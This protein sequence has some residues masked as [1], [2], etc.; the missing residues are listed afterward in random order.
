MYRV[1][2]HPSELEA[3][4]PPMKG[5]LNGP[6][7]TRIAYSEMAAPRCELFQMSDSTAGTTASGLAP[8]IP[9][10]KRQIISVW[11][12][13]ATADAMVNTA[14]PSMPS[15]NGHRLPNSSEA[16]AQ[17]TGPAAKPNTKSD[18]PSI[19]TSD[20][21]LKD[22]AAAAEPGA[23]TPLAKDGINVPKH[24]IVDM[25]ILREKA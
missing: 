2:R 16:G 7:K 19:P 23:K 20:P 12:S 17:M 14:P 10:K 9:A 1:Q 5:A 11:M 3:M 18:V 13:F 21:T 25:S 15:V 22:L 4:K 6:K 8:N 24:A